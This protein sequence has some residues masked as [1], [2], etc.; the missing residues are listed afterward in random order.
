MLHQ[1]YRSYFQLLLYSQGVAIAGS[2]AYLIWQ[3]ILT[4]L[5]QPQKDLYLL[6]ISI[7]GPFACVNH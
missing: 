6:L 7:Q 3:I 1:V 2:A 4:F 5:I